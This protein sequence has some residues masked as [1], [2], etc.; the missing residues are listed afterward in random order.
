MQRFLSLLFSCLLTYSAF[1][2]TFK[3]S[4][5]GILPNTG[6]NSAE[7]LTSTIKKLASEHKKVTLVLEEGRYDFYP[8]DSNRRQY[9][10]SNHDQVNPKNVGIAIENLSNVNILGNGSKF[11]FHDRMLPISIVNSSNISICDISIDFKKPHIAQVRVV[12]NDTVNHKITFVVEP[13][14]DFQVSGNRFINKGRNWENVLSSAIAFEPDTKRLVYNTSDIGF[15]KSHMELVNDSTVTVNFNNKRILKG[16]V[17]A[18]RSWYRPA[19]GIFI[20][21]SKNT[22]LVNTTVHYAE[23]MGLLAQ[24]SENITLD[25]FKVALKGNDDPRYFTTQ[26]DA[27][28]F[29]GCKG[30]IISKNGLYEGMMDDAINVHGT[31]LKV[32][33]RVNENTLIARYMHHQAWGF[34]WGFKGDKVQFIASKQMEIIGKQNTIK[35]IR[36]NDTEVVSGVKEFLIEFESKLDTVID[37]KTSIGI[38]NLTWTPEVLFENN[39][40]RNNRAR[41]TLFSTPKRTIVQGNTFDHTS[42]TAILLCGDCN[43]W[44]ETGACTNVTIRNNTFI[45]SLTSLFQFTNA[46]ISIYPEIP[47]LASQTK[48][49]HRNVKIYKNKFVTFDKPIIY[50]KSIDNLVFKN[51]IIETNQDYPQYHFIKSSFLFER[52]INVKIENNVYDFDFDPKTEIIFN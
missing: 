25:G 9:Y 30:K 44:F 52:A 15:G 32:I 46:I 49:F 12:E 28:H 10:I 43:G 47:D 39:I 22:T 26:A 19:P 2:Q 35:S 50:A 34:D 51:N 24:M 38:E 20:S 5:L 41:G 36:P 23:G 16:T 6:K 1:G 48:Y 21:L 40:I 8:T 29:S 18:M 31:Y 11:I 33:K 3:A 4:E 13:W 14:V 37:P 27:T 17:L 7:I 45:N 42:G